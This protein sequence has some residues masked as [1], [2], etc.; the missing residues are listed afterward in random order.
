MSNEYSEVLERTR[1]RIDIKKY[2]SGNIALATVMGAIVIWVGKSFP[3]SAH[4]A[5]LAIGVIL[6]ISLIRAN[7]VQ[8]RNVA[9]WEEGAIKN[10]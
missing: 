5:I 1:E 2:A 9:I 3:N 10:N 7:H 4:W 8:A 6:V